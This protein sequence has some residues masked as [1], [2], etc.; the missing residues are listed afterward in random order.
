MLAE[1]YAHEYTYHLPYAYQAEFRAAQEGAQAN[2][3][4]LW[5]PDTCAGQASLSDLAD[6]AAPPAFAMEPASVSAPSPTAPAP[7]TAP[8]Q[9]T[10]APTAV[11]SAPAPTAV[12]QPA[13]PPAPS[14][15][16]SPG[17]D[18]TAYVGKGDAHNCGDFASQADAQAVLRAD[19]RDP[20]RLD[21]DRDGI[22][23][24][25]NR[26]PRDPSRVPR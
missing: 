26:T 6:D 7:P 21:A 13:A 8:S 12:P 15:L 2:G 11:P 16:T 23:C 4:G 20:N 10:E 25:S 19:P 3:L 5:S 1:G 17:F 18:P 24:E 9:P 22:A 14:S